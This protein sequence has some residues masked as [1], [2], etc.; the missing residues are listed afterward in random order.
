MA[1]GEIETWPYDAATTIFRQSMRTHFEAPFMYLLVGRERAMLIDTGTGDADLGAAIDRAL[2]D[3]DVDLVVAHTHGHSDHVGGDA[4]L[5]GRPRTTVV[6]HALEVVEATFGLGADADAFGTFDLGDRVLDVIPV[7]GHERTHVAF[8]DRNTSLLFTGD[9]LYPGRLYVRDWPTYKASIARL[10]AFI[11]GGR[12]VRH[13]LGSHVEVSA[14][15]EEFADGEEHANER[16]HAL[17][18]RNLRDLHS[19]LQGTA[20]PRRIDGRDWIVIPVD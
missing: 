15:G 7:P 19:A 4:R 8:Y 12:A 2:C 20:A 3:H 16:W 5:A 14:T 18:E 13:I 6:G 1:E 17:D 9:V 11:D 10:V